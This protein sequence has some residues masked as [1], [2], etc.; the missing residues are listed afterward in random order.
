MTHS[1]DADP[2]GDLVLKVGSGDEVT[3]IRVQSKVLR[4]ASP[5]FAAMLSPRFAEG[6][7]L[8]DSKAIVDSTT[9]IDLPDDDPTAMSFLCRTL[10]FKE[11][12][13]QRK[14]Y[15]PGFL[16]E[17]AMIC[18][19]YNM[20][21][22]LSPWSHIWMETYHGEDQDNRFIRA[23][24]SY[25]WEHH[26]SFWK[27]T[28]DILRN[29]NLAEPN[30]ELSILPEK[31]IGESPVSII[32][33]GPVLLIAHAYIQVRSALNAR[34]FSTNSKIDLKAWYHYFSIMFATLKSTKEASSPANTL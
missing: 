6:Q 8:E 14:L 27:S 3:L 2:D 31:V 26:A 17:L 25:G 21:R 33:G 10:H 19:K 30:F 1:I 13:A 7:A 32:T 29:S 9:T 34:D 22:A 11:D 16:M 12:A 4:L 18:D 20:L 5:V 15:S 23:L 28:R 24:I